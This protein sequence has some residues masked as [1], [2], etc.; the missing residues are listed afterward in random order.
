MR[1]LTVDEVRQVSGGDGDMAT[2]YAG[3]L[4]GFTVTVAIGAGIALSIS[5]LTI[6]MAIALTAAVYIGGYSFG[7]G[8]N[9]LWSD[10]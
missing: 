7:W 10:S 9:W 3:E 6:P 5:S 8:L 1:E 4:I 2:L